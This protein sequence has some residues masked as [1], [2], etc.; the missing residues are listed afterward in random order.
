MAVSES[1]RLLD[2]VEFIKEAGTATD[3]VLIVGSGVPDGNTAPQSGAAKGSF[4]IQDDADDDESPFWLKVDNTGSDD[5]WKQ[6][7]I[8][9]EA[10]GRE[11]ASALT[12][13][14]DNKIYFRDT[15]IYVYSNAD[16]ELTITADSVINI[17][18]GT[19]QVAIQADGEINLEGTAKVTGA[20]MLPLDAGHGTATVESF[21]GAPSINL[22]ADGEMWFFAFEAPNDW[23]EASDL[24]LVFMVANEIAEDDGD[25]VSI[26]C[27]VHGYA[28]GEAMSD[29]GQSV[30]ATLNL[31]GGDQNINVVNRVT[32]TIDY[33]DGTHPIAA[34][35]LVVVKC[36]VNLG[37]AGEC[38]GPL[39]VVAQWV[40]YT[41][42]KLGT[43]T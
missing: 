15:G 17:G 18:D 2:P 9:D 24:T 1:T 40:E 23:D 38:T 31:T 32:G 35:D 3:V 33:D 11:L 22:D 19:N 26:T 16:G 6:V 5:D 12:M 36:T 43:A 27:Q 39:H 14:S 34:G 13:A 41:A 29:A 30:S 4:Y 7:F 20:L 25:D 37:D 28:D 21:N 10:G 8:E 42:D